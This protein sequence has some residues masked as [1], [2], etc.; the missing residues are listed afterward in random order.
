[1]KKTLKISVISII[2]SISLFVSLHII[3]IAAVSLDQDIYSTY[4]YSPQ[5]IREQF[6]KEGWNISVMEGSKLDSTYGPTIGLQKGYSI[7]GITIYK[8]KSIYLSSYDDYAVCSCNHEM[9]HFFDYTYMVYKK[10]GTLPSKSKEFYKLYGEELIRKTDS[11]LFID[12]E[13]CGVDEYFAQAYKY[14]CEDPTSLKKYYPNTYTYIENLLI[15]YD[16]IRN[17]E[18]AK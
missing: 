8:E 17:K 3:A 13:R 6:E 11:G 7:A 16:S 9:G 15:T 5:I 12:Y 10:G 2:T 18:T 14:Y 4:Q 1:M